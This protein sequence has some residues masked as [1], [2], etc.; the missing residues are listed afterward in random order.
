MFGDICNITL[1]CSLLW[2]H[3]CKRRSPAQ[4]QSRMRNLL[5][6][7][8]YPPIFQRDTRVCVSL[9]LLAHHPLDNT[10]QGQE[11]GWL[12]A[13]AFFPVALLN[14]VLRC[15]LTMVDRYSRHIH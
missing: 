12:R 5:H 14:F 3:L 11:L 9:R 13:A 15:P 2:T 8:Q 7:I 6:G 10:E 1:Y 4:E